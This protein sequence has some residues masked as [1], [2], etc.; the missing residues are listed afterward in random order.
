MHRFLCDFFMKRLLLHENRIEIQPGRRVLMVSHRHE[1]GCCLHHSPNPF[2][3]IDWC[4]HCRFLPHV[5][6]LSRHVALILVICLYVSLDFDYAVF[7]LIREC[8]RRQSCP[9]FPRHFVPRYIDPI[10]VHAA[11][12][13]P[14]YYG[15]NHLMKP[16]KLY[17]VGSGYHVCRCHRHGCRHE[18]TIVALS[19]NRPS[20]AVVEY[21]HELRGL[22]ILFTR[23]Q[24]LPD[25]L[26]QRLELPRRG[27]N[28][29]REPDSPRFGGDRQLVPPRN[30]LC[31]VVCHGLKQI[32][33]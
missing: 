10:S 1:D 2:R 28:L 27:L 29:F 25:V 33:H 9:W 18:E 23:L 20:H 4:H 26:P 24:Y 12:R 32:E 19:I 7:H 6:Q 5:P 31:S 11:F 16:S 30:E 8:H 3:G 21:L 17:I 13:H 22:P 14:L 15:R